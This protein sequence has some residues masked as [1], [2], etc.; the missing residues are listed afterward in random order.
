[1]F[2]YKG[3]AIPVHSLLPG[4]NLMGDNF[5]PSI[6]IP[7]QSTGD[8]YRD[9]ETPSAPYE[10][11][12][13]TDTEDSMQIQQNAPRKRSSRHMMFA[14]ELLIFSLVGWGWLALR[15]YMGATPVMDVSV[16]ICLLVSSSVNLFLALVYHTTDQFKSSAKGFLAH[17]LSVWVLYAYSL[18]ESTTP[19]QASL[20]CS[21]SST[22][23]VPGTYA[24]AYFGGLP[25]HQTVGAVT[26][27]FLSVF[28]LLAAVQVRVCIEDPREWLMMKTP[29]SIAC[30]V[31][32]Q[33][34][35]FAVNAG[36][37]NAGGLG[38]AV[39]VVA[40]IAWLV[41]VDFLKLVSFKDRVIGS[42]IQLIVEM[43]VTVMLAA[44]V[45]VLS[46]SVSGVPS[47]LLMVLFGGA[48]LWQS[49]A[50]ALALARCLRPKS[51]SAASGGAVNLVD[52]EGFESPSAP[53]LDP[54]TAP[55]QPD[56]T[57]LLARYRGRPV[58]ALPGVR[59]MRLHGGGRGKKA[60]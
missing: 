50:L 48:L 51:V 53:M 36:V 20:C 38:I 31:S 32:F 40:A 54:S 56:S 45:G 15:E 2:L 29:T 44:I 34:G 22:F 5:S 3:N 12:P 49:V 39:L 30:L 43:A 57:A 4:S 41:M 25:L 14:V 7:S 55:Q 23:S 28:L 26:L 9:M 58:M 10:K 37:C 21:G 52:S 8:K 47:A 17:T 60:W 1:M 35:L 18:I 33:L 6:V 59:E 24:L 27:A 19:R 42:L 16:I 13:D 46:A 11:D